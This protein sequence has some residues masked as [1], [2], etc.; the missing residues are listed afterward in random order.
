MFNPPKFRQGTEAGLVRGTGNN[1]ET[2][3]GGPSTIVLCNGGDTP[4]GSESEASKSEEE[5]SLFASTEFLLSV[6][7]PDMLSFR[8]NNDN[9]EAEA[10]D[11]S[12]DDD[13]NIIQVKVTPCKNISG[14][15][16]IT[17]QRVLFA[18]S[19]DSD[20]KSDLCVE[21]CIIGLFALSNNNIEDE[22]V[23]EEDLNKQ[24]SDTQSIFIQCNVKANDN[25]YCPVEIYLTPTIPCTED[26][27]EKIDTLLDSLFEALSKTIELNPP[28][29][30]SDAGGYGDDDGD[31]NDGFFF[32]TSSEGASEEERNQ[33]LERLDNLLIVDDNIV[34][35]Q[36]D[37]AEEESD[38]NLL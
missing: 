32:N 25:T 34:P 7:N 2:A 5:K 11:E 20:E 3:A 16:I 33:M 9:D 10:E 28:D 14:E 15:L 6:C 31:D 4:S 19:N 23:E 35:N 26:N 21:S 22:D 12:D 1:D 38:D 8:D 13:E 30:D 27:E 18:A 17:T 37:D 24:E 29:D 36:F